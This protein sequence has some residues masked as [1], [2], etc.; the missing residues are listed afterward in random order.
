MEIYEKYIF[1]NFVNEMDC[2]ELNKKVFDLVVCIILRTRKNIIIVHNI[3][4]STV[5]NKFKNLKE[6]TLVKFIFPSIKS[7]I[8][9][10]QVFC[11]RI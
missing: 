2:K 3:I 10:N 5:I 11:I 9:K 4:Y 8:Q 6:K 7:Q 1:N